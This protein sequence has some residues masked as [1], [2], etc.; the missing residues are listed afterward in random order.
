MDNAGCRIAAQVHK[1]QDCV[2][3]SKYN[4]SSLAAGFGN[5]QKL[6]SVV[7]K[8]LFRH[9]LA[10]I[11]ECTTASEV[12]K[13]LTILHA[14]RWVAEAW[15]QVASDTIKKCFQKAGI[16][17]ESFQVVQPSRISEES[18]PFLNI[19]E[20]KEGDDTEVSDQ[21]LS[22]LTAKLHD[23]DD[24]CEVP[25]LVS[26]ED[27]VPVC[28]EFANDKWDE[29]FMSDLAPANKLMCPDND[30]DIDS[31]G[32]DANTL[33]EPQPRIKSID[34]AIS[35]LGDILDF[36]EN[37]GYTK[38]AN[39]SHSLLDDLVRIHYASLTKQAS[40]TDYF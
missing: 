10:K 25:D 36:L 13:S 38:E 39:H 32:E 24:A 17:T 7:Q 20:G 35:C 4:I 40:I 2:F 12:T 22:E 1:H 34:E 8:L 26:A 3:T 31:E 28:A 23:K 5:H 19:D 27:D 30:N 37:R 15:N 11:E 33:K 14:I 6:Q 21:E 9:I 18:D 16:L 29:E